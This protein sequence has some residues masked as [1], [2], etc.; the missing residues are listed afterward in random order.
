MRAVDLVYLWQSADQGLKLIVDPN[1]STRPGI[2]V[3][4]SQ[5]ALDVNL[6]W[7]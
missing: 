7:L 6:A 2:T 3:D 1:D 5:T 4:S